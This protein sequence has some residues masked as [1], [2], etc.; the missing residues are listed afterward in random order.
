MAFHEEDIEILSGAVRG[1]SIQERY[2]SSTKQNL[3]AITKT[4][5]R[6]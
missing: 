1:E 3:T 2:I 6:V 5:M 4:A